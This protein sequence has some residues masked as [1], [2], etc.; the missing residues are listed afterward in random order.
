[1]EG[2]TVAGIK[3]VAVLVAVLVGT[4][5][6][7]GAVGAQTQKQQAPNAALLAQPER[8]TVTV[9]GLSCPFCAYGLEKRLKKLEGVESLSIDFN[10]GKVILAVRDGS[11]ASD[12]RIRRLVKEGGFQVVLIERTALA[13]SSSRRSS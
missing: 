2:L 5:L 11:K 1:M 12:D 10:S 7:P 3:M 9:N 4:A 6:V 8:I 13:D